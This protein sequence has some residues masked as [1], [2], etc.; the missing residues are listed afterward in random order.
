MISKGSLEVISN[1]DFS[2]KGIPEREFEQFE[3][4]NCTFSSVAGIEYTDCIFT[5]CNFS[6]A[7][8]ANCKMNDVTFNNCKLLGVNFSETKDFGFLVRFDNCILDYAIFDNKKL[9][10]SSFSNCKIHNADFTQAD[11][12]KCKFY[13]CDFWDSVF[14]NTNAAGVDF[15]T[16]KNFTIDPVTNNIRKAKFLSS[17]LAGLLTKFDIIIK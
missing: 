7:V 12:S 15:T 11:L 13:N 17:D 6:N 3:F 16:S 2:E 14:V 1:I 5:D 8:L 10:K 9:N 4:V